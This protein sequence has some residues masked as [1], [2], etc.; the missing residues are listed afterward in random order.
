MKKTTSP[1]AQQAHAQR[2]HLLDTLRGLPMIYMILFHIGYDLVYMF[3]ADWLAP[4]FQGQMKISPIFTA[5][6]VFLA[7]ITVRFSRNP[8]K[9]GARLLLIAACFTLVT[10]FIFAGGAIYFG[11]LHLISCGMLVYSVVSKY[12]DKLPWWLGAALCAVIFAFTYNTQ[13]GFFGFGELAVSVPEILTTN[14]LLYPFGF[15]TPY[16]ISVDYLPLLPWLFMFLGGTFVGRL[17]V[18]RKLPKLFYR[19]ICPPI[20]WL[21][22]NSLLIYILHQPIVFG[23]LYLIYEIIV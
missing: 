19:D 10:S 8:A 17:I 1:A 18:N 22:R 2:V 13:R 15:I 14:N 6:F 12:T 11:V 20:T 5:S 7:G 3:G 16:Y 4:F 9:H 21:G 23:L